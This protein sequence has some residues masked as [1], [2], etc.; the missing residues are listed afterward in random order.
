MGR[1]LVALVAAAFVFAFSVTPALADSKEDQ[2]RSHHATRWTVMEDDT[3]GITGMGPVACG[4]HSY[5]VV[6]GSVHFV[7]LQQGTVGSDSVAL[8][9]GKATEDW[10]MLKVKVVDQAGRV[11]RVEGKQH[12][13]ASWSAGQNIDVGPID[14]YRLTIDIRIEGTHD[15]HQVVARWLPDGSFV[16]LSDKG[17]CA[18]LTLFS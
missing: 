16:V 2:H 17:T 3:T 15:G 6:S 10:T 11:H 14:S 7:W 8:S 4:I 1:R 9:D 12:V 13:S 18:G 5:T